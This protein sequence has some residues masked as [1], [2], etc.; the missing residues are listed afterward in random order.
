MLKNT[1]RWIQVHRNW[2]PLS[3]GA[4]DFTISSECTASTIRQTNMDL[5]TVH[6]KRY[7]LGDMELFSSFQN[8]PITSELI[9]TAKRA[10]KQTE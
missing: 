10:R 8:L 2:Q 1:F 7:I 5:E 6:N 3:Q 9:N 4:D